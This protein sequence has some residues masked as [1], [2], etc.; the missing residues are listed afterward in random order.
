MPTFLWAMKS[1]SAAALLVIAASLSFGQTTNKVIV[2]SSRHSNKITSV[3]IGPAV[4]YYNEEV[5]GFHG[6][7]IVC[8]NDEPTC[9][10]PL[11]RGSGY[12]QDGG[13]QIYTGTNITIRWK[14]G[15]DGTS[16]IQESY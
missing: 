13:P 2:K 5:A 15:V 14:N 3:D 16:V 6:D 1:S 11:E 10:M 9:Y 8:N 4:Q 12:I 7:V